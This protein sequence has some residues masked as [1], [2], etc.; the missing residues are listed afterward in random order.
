VFKLTESNQLRC[1]S[2]DEG[3]EHDGYIITVDV[4]YGRKLLMTSSIDQ[5]IKIWS[6][7]KVLLLQLNVDDNL[8]G[9]WF[10]NQVGDLLVAH[11]GKVSL[12]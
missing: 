8:H 11:D 1:Y 10:I 4:D 6:W 2:N 9:A 5:R 12:S 3:N 7:R